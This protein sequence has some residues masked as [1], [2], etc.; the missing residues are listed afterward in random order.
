M[1]RCFAVL[2]SLLLLMTSAPLVSADND[3][4]DDHFNWGENACP[5]SHRVTTEA[6][7]P[8]CDQPGHTGYTRCADCALLLEGVDEEL[9]MVDHTYD[10][11]CDM[12]CNVCG[13]W[14]EVGDHEYDAG[15]VI[16]APTCGDM[17]WM[18]YTCIHCGEEYEDIIPATG[19][20]VY[21]NACANWCDVCGEWRA[22]G[23]H[24]YD[25]G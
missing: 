21:E 25:E 2:L 24:E 19:E 22:V 20:H 4:N 15:E 5:H 8:T 9:P 13:A 10:N 7:A 6:K 1:K 14:R 12:D 16:A 17:G 18:V 3:Y 11:A 23:D